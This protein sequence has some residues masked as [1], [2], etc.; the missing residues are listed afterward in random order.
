M[1]NPS[2][3]T[4]TQATVSKDIQTIIASQLG[5]DANDVLPTSRLVEDLGADSL[6]LVETVLAIE[7]QYNIEM[8]VFFPSAPVVD[9]KKMQSDIDEALSSVEHLVRTTCGVLNVAYTAPQTFI[10]E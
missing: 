1:P 7:E 2:T 4:R 6:D 9:H 10:A 5:I 8:E 3:S